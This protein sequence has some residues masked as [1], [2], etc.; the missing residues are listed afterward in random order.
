L[1][2]RFAACLLCLLLPLSAA[3][4][5]SFPPVLPGKPPVFPG[6][7]GTHP[8]FRTE[9]WYVTGWLE[10]RA[11]KALGFQITFFRSRTGKGENNPSRFAPSQV[12]VAHAA[13]S[14]PERGRLL[15]DQRM[16][17]QGF[18]LAEAAQ[19]SLNVRLDNWQFL[20]D[21]NA[22]RAY[23]QARE[24]T[25]ELSFTPSQPPLPQGEHG[26]SK[27]SPAPGAASHYYSLPHLQVQGT[28]SRDKDRATVTGSA[29]LDHEW[30]SHYLDKQATGWDWVGIN[31]DGGGALMAFR[32]RA[33]TG[34]VLWAG[35][36]YRDGAGNITVFNP[37]QVR[38]EPRRHWTSP[39]TGSAYPVAMAVHIGDLSLQLDPLMDDQELDA[40]KTTGSVYWEGA[41][42]ASR[43][44]RQVG[45]GYLELTGYA[46]PMDF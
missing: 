29:W 25:L 40:R 46:T 3:A 31:L 1:V 45:K 14:D 20:R 37:G 39:R 24:F 13:I 22:Y 16:A 41:V 8:A 12:Y 23:I 35:A 18:G 42:R 11:G 32:M 6:D 10:T 19:G 27:K 28:L 4:D 17:R 33:K 36:T 30:S 43:V 44:G 38:F 2:T 34:G 15:H 9:W 5:A 7:E 21:G 26:Y